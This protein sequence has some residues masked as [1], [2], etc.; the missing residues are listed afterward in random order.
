MRWKED[1]DHFVVVAVLNLAR[2]V[3]RLRVDGV[4]LL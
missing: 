4:D 2:V 3:P 1:V